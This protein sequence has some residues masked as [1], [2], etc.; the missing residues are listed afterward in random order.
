[1]P[2]TKALVESKTTKLEA[3]QEVFS[4]VPKS[5][6]EAMN[7]AKLISDSDLAPKDYKGKPGNTLIAIQMGAE[8]G[9]S[10]MRAIQ[11]IA[12]INGR[13][14]L[15]GDLGKALLLARGCR[16]EE[17]D[18]KD[19]KRLG[20]GWCRITRPDGSE[21]IVR[22]FSIDDAKTAG[23]WGKQSP[24]SGYPSRMLMWRAFWFAARDGAADFLSGFAGAEEVRDYVDA[25]AVETKAAEAAAA[26]AIPEPQRNGE[27]AEPPASNGDSWKSWK[28]MKTDKTMICATCEEKVP[29]GLHVLVDAEKKEVH[30]VDH[31]PAY[32]NA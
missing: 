27:A 12:V 14:C 11:N 10:P 8:I 5:L 13:P 4:M 6:E 15:W 18:L 22:T 31:F 19:V 16:I 30:H 1:M 21:P 7:L 32:A 17:R 25:V 24:W 2:K 29:V 9:I 26:A 28:K 3:V 20:E 23:L